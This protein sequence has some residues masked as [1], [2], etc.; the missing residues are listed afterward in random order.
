[1]HQHAV[2]QVITQ[3]TGQHHLLDVT[4]K[5]T[6]SSMLSLWLTRTTSCSMI[7]PASSSSVT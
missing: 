6:M 5:R 3:A 7:G 2:F 1:V 4:A